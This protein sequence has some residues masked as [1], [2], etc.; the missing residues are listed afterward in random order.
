MN[1]KTIPAP[2]N[3][4]EMG[5]KGGSNTLKKHGKNHFA[6]MGKKSGESKRAKIAQ[7]QEQSGKVL[8]KQTLV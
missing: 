3:A 6:Q 1:I 7:Q 4:S 2:L 8:D 5:K